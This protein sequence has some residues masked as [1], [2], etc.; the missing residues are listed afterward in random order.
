MKRCRIKGSGAI[1]AG[2]PNRLETTMTPKPI[3]PL[4][5][6]GDPLCRIPY[7]FC[8]CGCGG[9]TA[10]ATG[11]V[12]AYGWR[13]GLPKRYI[14]GHSGVPVG[15]H[16]PQPRTEL[17]QPTDPSIRLIALTQSKVTTISAHRY[18][19][20]SVH[21]WYALKS[22]T[23]K[24]FNGY[25]AYRKVRD[26][27]GTISLISMHN[28]I[29]PSPEGFITDHINGDTLDN[30]DENLRTVTSSQSAMN[31]GRR[32]DN[33]GKPIGVSRTKSGNY[34]AVIGAGGKKFYLGTYKTMERAAAAYE[35][36][37]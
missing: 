28:T 1:N 11:N 25:Y 34:S 3:L 35:R 17:V 33:Y 29:H 16:A 32:R 12:T 8:H 30:R 31:R 13:K 7:G 2:K 6:C 26:A 23:N 19:S 18:P 5:V 24:H 20:L 15:P 27:D 10:L 37:R 21:C 9:K 36:A 4:C 22:T 14:H